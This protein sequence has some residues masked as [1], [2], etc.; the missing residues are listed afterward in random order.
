MRILILGAYGL[1]GQSVADRLA[2]AGHEIVGMGRSVEAARLRRPNMTW[3]AADIAKL[4]KP[5]SWQP[6]LARIDAVVNCA[7][8]LQDGARDNVRALQVTAMLALSPPVKLMAPR[9]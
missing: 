3:I 7:G 4:V 5:E 6:Y 1:I 9:A 2:A 8:A